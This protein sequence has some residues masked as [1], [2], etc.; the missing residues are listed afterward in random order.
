MLLIDYYSR[1]MWVT[2]LREKSEVLEKFKIFKARVE[3]EMGLKL[4]CLRSDRGGEFTSGEFD[5]FC[6]RNGIRR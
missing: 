2:F 3:T 4:K 5:T 1:M 6:E